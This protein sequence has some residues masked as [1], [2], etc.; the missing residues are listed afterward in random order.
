MRVKAARQT[1]RA[2]LGAIAWATGM[3]LSSQVAMASPAATPTETPPLRTSADT[4]A[5]P[6]E[7]RRADFGSFR[8]SASARELADWVVATGDHRGRPFIVVDKVGARV[9]AFDAD[10][11]LRGTSPALL[12]LARGDHS[13]PGIGERPI[14]SIRPEERTTP[15]GR[16]DAEMGR[17]A[18][19]EDILWV[20]YDNAVS[21]HR[22]RATNPAEQRLRRLASATVSD[23]RISYGCINLPAAF[24]DGVVKALF[25]PR[26]GVVYVLPETRSAG[27]VFGLT[28][29][30]RTVRR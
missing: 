30:V 25:S 22:V 14:A 26:N 7:A 2:R 17:N 10:G 12:G 15:A 28:G 13:V 23:N 19:G 24:Y 18:N 11:R 9:I 1:T 6:A 21:M 29:A 8:P 4:G 27:Q 20:D 3:A 16:F 5:A